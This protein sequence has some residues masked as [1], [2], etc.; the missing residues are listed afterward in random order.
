MY[1]A[2]T[3]LL[4]SL[5]IHSYFH[6]STSP[7]IFVLSI[8]E[9]VLREICWFSDIF[10]SSLMFSSL[11]LLFSVREKNKAGHDVWVGSSRVISLLTSTLM[12][13][14]QNK[15]TAPRRMADFFLSLKSLLTKHST[16]HYTQCLI[17][18]LKNVSPPSHNTWQ[19]GLGG[20]Q[21]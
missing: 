1:L 16:V 2:I 4:I 9:M 10:I 14:Y 11:L 21:L 12:T 17:L 7:P 6:F 18:Q 13:R 20:S 5:Q 3:V 15:N 19:V 8:L